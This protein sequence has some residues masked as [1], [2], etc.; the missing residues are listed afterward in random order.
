MGRYTCYSNTG[1]PSTID[2]FLSSS[3]LLDKV[4]YL[5]VNDLTVHSIHCSIT[6]SFSLRS[7]NCD[8]QNTSL[9]YEPVRKFAWSQLDTSKFLESLASVHVQKELNDLSSR[10]NNINI[11]NICHKDI[12]DKASVKLIDIISETGK[13]A[14]MKMK[15][16]PR[17]RLKS[18]K[19]KQN[20]RSKPW[21]DDK[22][23]MLKTHCS[24]LFALS[25]Q[26]PFNRRHRFEFNRIKKLYKSTIKSNKSH[27]EKNI[28]ASLDNFHKSNP[29][30][31]WKLLSDLRGLDD[32]QQQ[33]PIAMDQW[34][35]HFSTLLNDALK[36]NKTLIAEIDSY[37]D[38]NRDKIFNELN[39][40]ISLA[41]T[42]EA[43]KS[44][45]INKAA[46][47]DGIVNEMFKT[48]VSS[49][50]TPLHKIFNSILTYG[51]FPVSWCTNTLSPLFKKGDQFD[52]RNYR[53]I[54][55]ASSISKI[56]LSIMQKRLSNFAKSNQLIPS[57]QIAYQ[58]NSSTS[59]HILTLK[60]LIDKYINRASKFHL[61]V[62]F[63]DF[64]AAFDT[65]WRRA[66]LYKLVKLGIG[67]NF[68]NVI[69]SMYRNVF[70]RIKIDGYLSERI[71]S[72]IGVKQ[73]CVL[74][75]LLFN[76]FPSDLPSIFSTD[77]HPVELCNLKLN[78]LMFADDLVLVSQSA[79]GLQNC[80]NKLQTYCKK[81]CLTVNT[82]KTK[83]VI[84]NKGG[85]RI[86]RYT[87]RLNDST[88]EIVQQYCYLGIIFSATGNFNNACN[89][90]YDKALRAFYKFKRLQPQNNIRQALKLFDCL[91]IPILT[92]SSVIWGPLYAKSMNEENL[93]DICN[94]SPIERL[95][96][97]L[98]KFL[99][100]VH[101]KS[102]NAAVRGETGRYPLLI[103]V[104]N[105]SN[106]YYGRV[107]S[108]DC[109]TLVKISCT[110]QSI[111]NLNS[112][113]PRVMDN[114]Q[115][116]FHGA[117]P[118]KEVL[119]K[120]YH[121]KWVSHID[122]CRSEGKLKLYA[123]IKKSFQLENYLLQFPIYFRQNFTKLRISAHN[124]A[125]ETGRY[126]KPVALALTKRTCF[127]C[128]EIETEFHFILK[129]PL[130]Q[131]ERIS[132]YNKLSNFLILDTSPSEEFF[133]LLMSGLQG[134]EEVG[135][136]VCDYINDCV[137]IR[138]ET[139]S[140]KIETDILQRAKS[141]ITRYG[142]VSKRPETLDM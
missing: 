58:Q 61:F 43:I 88:I 100:G 137:K 5:T 101:S 2:Y 36:P 25:K 12:I 22:C 93:Y 111:Q 20:S 27:F 138:S 47:L 80:L 140:H 124:L 57:C 62:C 30:K 19:R 1:K 108:L 135:K 18:G 114:M 32:K 89:A 15:C 64:R 107:R 74:S 50:L 142:R 106:R 26:D 83:V 119:K 31:Y 48:G 49:F 109:N 8:N 4:H 66:L 136:I 52:P 13:S 9:D 7:V 134:D 72:S 115:M 10:F 87:F 141:T 103:N 81:W 127:H 116:N 95:N 34:V 118:L 75:P 39:F 96:L 73:G 77:C 122:S 67:G 99:L 97:K 68:L 51:H 82:D 70:Y 110:D 59:D 131:N 23:K 105:L 69:D 117:M 3:S 91:I 17:L 11:A 139:L 78:C 94:N 112:S 35:K 113:W 38:L 104:L 21:F 63:V 120:R 102:T 98:C 60:N 76:L 130:Y 126:S 85:H 129:C 41:E 40:S 37:I 86:S 16:K 84:F 53:G 46:G 79:E 44:L 33:N 55:V 92:Y 71:P 29:K 128:K 42:A 65:V 24:Q 125:I 121:E 90:L 133:H 54:A 28:W 45:K 56:F 14:G 6:S 132:L 123:E